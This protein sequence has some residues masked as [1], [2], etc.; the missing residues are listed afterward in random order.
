MTPT[1]P[2]WLPLVFAFPGA[3][4]LLLVVLTLILRWLGVDD[5]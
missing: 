4:L 2:L 3:F 1:D 5:T